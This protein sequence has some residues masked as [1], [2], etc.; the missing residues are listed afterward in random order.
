MQ[1]NIRD[2]FKGNGQFELVP[3]TAQEHPVNATEDDEILKEDEE[4]LAHEQ[5][6]TIRPNR[7]PDHK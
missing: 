7:Y 5:K 1:S 2:S 3:A 6:E 4:Q